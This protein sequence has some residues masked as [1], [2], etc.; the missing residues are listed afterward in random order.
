MFHSR[1][2]LNCLSFPVN[3]RKAQLWIPGPFGI[4]VFSAARDLLLRI[5]G[6][7]PASM[8]R[9]AQLWMNFVFWTLVLPEATC[10]NCGPMF[11]RTLERK[12]V[13]RLSIPADRADPVQ[14]LPTR[15]SFAA[16]SR[17]SLTLP[18]FQAK[19]R[20]MF[21]IL[22]WII[23][24]LIA[25]A[26]AKWIMPGKDPGGLVITI[27]LGVAGAFLGG[28]LGSLAGIGSIAGGFNIKSM[29]L[30]I[31]GALVLLYAHRLLKR[32]TS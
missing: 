19:D 21:S 29:G 11:R 24:G 9:S 6:G 18:G 27:L 26:L 3:A 8:A 25:G 2:T 15:G 4:T 32:M 31:V 13:G 17:G 7:N 14:A 28:Y 30:A 22:S 10:T 5:L 20:R 16:L 23:F 1:N 12:T